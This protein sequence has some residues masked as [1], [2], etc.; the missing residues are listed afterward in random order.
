MAKSLIASLT[1]KYK[2]PVISQ[3]SN[4]LYRIIMGPFKNPS[5]RFLMLQ[6]LKGA[7]YE[8]AF[9]KEMFQP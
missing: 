8:N 9:G 1:H 3:P 2:T 6:Q 7:G 4:G 5:E